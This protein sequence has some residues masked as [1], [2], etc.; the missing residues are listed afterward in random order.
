M[1]C[2]ENWLGTESTNDFKRFVV[3]LN[4]KTRLSMMKIVIMNGFVTLIDICG[5]TWGRLGQKMPRCVNS[6]K[7][8]LLLHFFH[9]NQPRKS[10]YFSQDFIAKLIEKIV[11][12]V[13]TRFKAPHF[14]TH[15]SSITILRP[16]VSFIPLMF[17]L[18]IANREVCQRTICFM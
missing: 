15:L 3:V 7:H 10:L 17:Y 4:P 18:I 1:A 14:D 12:C 13:C 6:V 16:I 11:V 8:E 5:I 9:K 2:N